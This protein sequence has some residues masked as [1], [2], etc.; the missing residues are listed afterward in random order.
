VL[1]ADPLVAIPASINGLLRPYQRAGV[2]F[3]YAQFSRDSGSILGDDMGL[4][5]TVQCIA[6]MAAVGKK[7]LVI[8]PLT[9]LS[10][11]SSELQKFCGLRSATLHGNRNEKRA[12]LAAVTGKVEALCVCVFV[13]VCVYVCVCVG[14]CFSFPRADGLTNTVPAL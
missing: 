2:E 4:G 5:K 14:C 13:C 10:Q 7:W 12:A 9:V 11:W 1:C 8:A 6:L 3:L